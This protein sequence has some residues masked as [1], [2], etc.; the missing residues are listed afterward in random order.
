MHFPSVAVARG[1]SYL[2]P[3]CVLSPAW[4]QKIGSLP[5]TPTAQTLGPLCVLPQSQE[6]VS[7]ATISTR[8]WVHPCY[9]LSAQVRGLLSGQ[10]AHSWYGDNGWVSSCVTKPHA[11]G[12]SKHGN[13]LFTKLQ[14]RSR[15]PRCEAGFP[16]GL[17]GCIGSAPRG[18]PSAVIVTWCPHCRYRLPL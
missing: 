4:G 5:G 3:D 18:W 6:S 2:C 9:I 15:S 17:R 14:A 1:C 10:R 11:L 16:L 13:G 8:F 12:G 7:K